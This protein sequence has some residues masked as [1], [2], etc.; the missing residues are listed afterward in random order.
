MPPE[1]ASS[2]FAG[3]EPGQQSLRGGFYGSEDLFPLT[4]YYQHPDRWVGPD[5]G[6]GEAFLLGEMSA[7]AL[8]QLPL[9][10]RL[11]GL[12]V[13]RPRSEPGGFMWGDWGLLALTVCLLLAY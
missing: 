12:G 8:R 4:P 6:V 1:H 7:S 9:A 3:S 10:W 11:G 2:Y 13:G 5:K